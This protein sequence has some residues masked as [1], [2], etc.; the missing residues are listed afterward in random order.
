M[1][2]LGRA[3][4]LEEQD[5]QAGV[6]RIINRK[7]EKPLLING[8]RVC[9]DCENEISQQRIQALPD[10]VRCTICQEF[11]EKRLKGYG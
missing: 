7:K 2:D 11:F 8:R 3:A 6:T 5:R 4:W 1:G 9:L 10:A